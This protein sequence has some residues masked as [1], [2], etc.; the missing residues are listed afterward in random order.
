[1]ENAIRTQKPPHIEI[2]DD[3]VKSIL[4]FALNEQNSAIEHI[5]RG[6]IENR[7]ERIKCLNENA[8]EIKI[9]LE[10]FFKSLKF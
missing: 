2:A 3:F 4:D 6:I 7:T 10:D 1:M 8:E 5:A 9:S